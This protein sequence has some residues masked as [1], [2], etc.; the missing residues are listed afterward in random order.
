M[1]LYFCNEIVTLGCM[2]LDFT[3]DKVPLKWEVQ[4]H[5]SSWENYSGFPFFVKV[6]ANW[7]VSFTS[8]MFCATIYSP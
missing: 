7:E 2:A 8:C 5:Y 6:V 4:V 3:E 1:F